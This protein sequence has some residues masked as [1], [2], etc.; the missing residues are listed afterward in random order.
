MISW[1][2]EAGRNRERP[3]LQPGAPAPFGWAAAPRGRV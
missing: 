1:N 2:G 3:A